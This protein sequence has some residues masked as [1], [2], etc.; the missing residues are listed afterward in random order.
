MFE[1]IVVAIDGSEHADRAIEIACSLAKQYDSALHFVHTPEMDTVALAVGAG[2]FSLQPTADKVTSAGQE[3]MDLAV[4]QA[5]KSGIET[6]SQIIG[7]G[8]PANEAVKAAKATKAD[9]I[10]AGRRGLGA[11]ASV[12]MGSTSQRISH[13]APCA[14]L[15]VI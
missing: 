13:E 9:L 5:A 3:V 8:T 14:V 10:V 2:A 4:A 12:L 7:N 6:A 11:V 1:N 15:T